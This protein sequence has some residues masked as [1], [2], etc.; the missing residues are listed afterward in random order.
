MWYVRWG[1][2]VG[3]RAPEHDGTVSGMAERALS[4]GKERRSCL[5]RA[6][7]PAQ[8]DTSEGAVPIAL[9]S[10]VRVGRSLYEPNGFAATVDG[11]KGSSNACT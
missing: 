10:L 4:I 1:W 9:C 11:L 6:S 2:E 7:L 5:W 8:V 3:G